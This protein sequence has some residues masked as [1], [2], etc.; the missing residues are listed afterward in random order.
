MNGESYSSLYVCLFVRAHRSPVIC[1]GRGHLSNPSRVC[2]SFLCRSAGQA[3]LEVELSCWCPSGANR[4]Q[5]KPFTLQA[6]GC[7][8]ESRM[9]VTCAPV[10]K[11]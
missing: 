11:C 3:E 8:W 4:L 9:V 5:G 2:V 6:R 10:L 1:A 7:V